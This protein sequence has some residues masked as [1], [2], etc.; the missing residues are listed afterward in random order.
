MASPPETPKPRNLRAQARHRRESL[1]QVYVPLGLA[2]AIVLAVMALTIIG[3]YGV[4]P[5]AHL[6]WADISLIYLVVLA[7]AGGLVVLGLLGGLCFGLGY[8]LRELPP[9]FKLAQDFVRL[10]SIRAE[11]LSKRLAKLFIAPHA[12][13]AAARKTLA[14]ARSIITSGRKG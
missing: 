1:W 12:S 2:I 7:A 11:E 4:T 10:L 13:T 5:L 9:Y 3:A 6:V 8:V 14:S